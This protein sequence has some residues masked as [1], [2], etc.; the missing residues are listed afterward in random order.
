MPILAGQRITAGSL[1]RL[2]PT[3][4]AA[5]AT[6]ATGNIVSTTQTDV[7]GLSVTVVTTTANATYDVVG[8]FDVLPGATSA[9]IYAFGFLV[10]DGIAD[11]GVGIHGLT[12]LNRDIATQTWHGTLGAAGSHTLKLTA[13]L[14]GALGTG[15]TVRAQNSKIAVMITEVA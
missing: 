4:Y 14:S 5:V 11:F 15:V 13:A 9:S 10:I 12:N 8:T 3:T 2:Q 6:A 1:N 7:P